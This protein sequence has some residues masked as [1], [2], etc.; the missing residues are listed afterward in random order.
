MMFGWRPINKNESEIF[1]PAE[2]KPNPHTIF[3]I[4]LKYAPVQ[5]PCLEII[6]VEGRYK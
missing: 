1:T 4:K 3:P 6:P 2:I 5:N